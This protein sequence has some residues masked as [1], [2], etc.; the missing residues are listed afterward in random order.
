MKNRPYFLLIFLF[1]IL[2]CLGGGWVTGLVTQNGIKTWYP[3]LNKP[4]GTPPDIAFPIVWSFLYLLMALSLTL[5]WTSPSSNKRN[6]FIFFGAQ[7]FFN[8]IW[9]LLF[10][11]MQD[12]KTAL[13]DISLLWVFILLTIMSFWRHT[14]LGSYLLI[15]Y[16]AWVTYAFYL[17]LYIW[18]YN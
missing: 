18:K 2:L 3:F 10:F 14:H 1:S 4:P 8:F 15:P 11:Y 16:L 12:P 6:A 13:I 7:L 17:N 5:M 9:S